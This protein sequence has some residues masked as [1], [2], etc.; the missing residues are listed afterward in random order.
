MLRRGALLCQ[1][2]RAFKTKAAEKAAQQ[3]AKAAAGGGRDPYS[4]F[5]EAIVSQPDA[6]ASA[7]A[8][9]S[10][11]AWREH[12]AA[13]SRA[14]IGEVWPPQDHSPREPHGHRAMLTSPRAFLS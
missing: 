10:H 3:Q 9:M 4:L 13:Y 2:A 5:K 1:G 6:E 11:K 8:R 14:K 7:A 12:R